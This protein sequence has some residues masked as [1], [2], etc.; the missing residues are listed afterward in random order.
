MRTFTCFTHD[1]TSRVPTLSF[2]LA[3]DERRA[4]ELAHRELMDALHPVAVELHEAGRL[5]WTET[6]AQDRAAARVS[7]PTFLA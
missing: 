4:R 6:A 2:I 3:K 1:A 5:L 7:R